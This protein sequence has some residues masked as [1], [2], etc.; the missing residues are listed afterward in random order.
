MSFHILRNSLDKQPDKQINQCDNIEN[1]G[2][3]MR[4]APLFKTKFV[5]SNLLMLETTF[6]ILQ[7]MKN[8][9]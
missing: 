2:I 8:W 4:Q 9:C 5:Y 6:F 7:Q 1:S 3:A